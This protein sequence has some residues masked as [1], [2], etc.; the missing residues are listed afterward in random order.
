MFEIFYPDILETHIADQIIIA[1]IDGEA[2]LIIQLLL[3]M[4]QNVDIDIIQ[5]FQNF[6]VFNVSVN[7]DKD[8]VRYI[9]PKGRVLHGDIF[10]TAGKSQTSSVDGGAIVG[11]TA[12]YAV[13]QYIVTGKYIHAVAPTVRTDGFYIA[14]RYAVR[15]SCGAL[16]SDNSFY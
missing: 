4:V 10:A 3:F 5:V 1:C 8:G 12:K 7:T 15:S 6:R 2:A 11:V 9:R 16:G 13:E 14:Y